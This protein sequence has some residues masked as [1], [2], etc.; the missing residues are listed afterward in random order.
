MNGLRQQ[1]SDGGF[2]L[3]E[4]LVV[5]G[6]IAILAALLL[7]ALGKAKHQA[8]RTAC[9]NNL[10]QLGLGFHSFAHDHESKFPMQVVTE[11]G[12]TLVPDANQ[13]TPLELFAPAYSHLQALS[14]ELTTPNLL[15]CPTDLRTAAARFEQ[16]NNDRISYFV[17]VTA[18]Y[19]QPGTILAGDRNLTSA[20]SG[21]TNALRWTDALH[22][23]KGN[24]LFADGHV[25]RW[26]NPTL[27][28]AG[29]Q[30]GAQNF[31][32]PDAGQTAPTAG[33]FPQPISQPQISDSPANGKSSSARNPSL[34]GPTRANPATWVS[35]PLARFPFANLVWKEFLTRSNAN[36]AATIASTNQVVATQAAAD[37]NKVDNV[38]LQ[39]LQRLIT[40]TNLLLLLLLLLLAYVV[41][42]EWRKWQKRRGQ[43][44]ARVRV[45]ENEPIEIKTRIHVD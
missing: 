9:A 38:M 36:H 14:N 13:T 32:L 44:P 39:S 21:V 30:G 2:T 6:I 26:K 27:T 29:S 43:Q 3:I 7:P 25:E 22:Q 24:V 17:G 41:W 8:K 45:Y 16:L 20:G 1:H 34:T 12:G 37:T 42:R 28:W 40:S 15:T 4:L 11:D 23:N 19:S 33:L 31:V 18:N 5:I 35:V 10:Q